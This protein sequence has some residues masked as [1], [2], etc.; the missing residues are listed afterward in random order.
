[1][2]RLILETTQIARVPVVTI[3]AEGAW[4]CPLVFFAHGMIDQAYD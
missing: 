1:M 2:S 3:C 4:R